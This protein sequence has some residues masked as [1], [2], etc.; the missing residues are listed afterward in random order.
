LQEQMAMMTMDPED[1][2]SSLTP[3]LR[4]RVNELQVRHSW[5]ANSRRCSSS[6]SSSA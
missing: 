3:Q 4:A 1:F 2:I 5:M 6:S